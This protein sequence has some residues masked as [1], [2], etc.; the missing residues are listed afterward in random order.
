MQHVAAPLPQ[1]FA[2]GIANAINAP[3]IV[4]VLAAGLAIGYLLARV[5]LE[6]QARNPLQAPMML[7]VACSTMTILQVSTVAGQVIHAPARSHAYVGSHVGFIVLGL[8]CGG[9][10]A[11]GVALANRR[12][13]NLG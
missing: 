3:T 1:T 11:A 4:C 5:R 6:L 7:A 13:R 8:L 2:D 10:C 12:N 9:G